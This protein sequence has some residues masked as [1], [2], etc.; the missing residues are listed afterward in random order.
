MINSTS[1]SRRIIVL[2]SLVA[3]TVTSVHASEPKYLEYFPEIEPYE[4]GYLR[5][6]DLHDIYYELCGNPDGKPVMVLHGG[7]GGGSYPT[8]R[9][10]H[11]PSKW[12]I[13][14]HDQ[15]GAGKS[16]PHCELKD[17]NTAALVEDVEALRKYLGL[18]KVHVFG[19]SWGS[20]LGVAY[21]EKYPQNVESLVLR[22]VFLGS[23]AEID[24]FYH[25]GVITHFP[26]QYE[27]LEAMIPEPR[28]KHFPKQLF[29]L[30]R[31]GDAETKR[32]IAVGWASYEIR[33]SSINGS[34]EKV[35]EY[36]KTW[37]PYDFS[38]IENYYMANGCF[39]KDEELLANAGK[40]A[41]I[42]TIIVQGRFDVVCPPITAWK[43]H[44]KLPKSRLVIVE[45]GAHSAGDPPMRSALIEAV[46]SVE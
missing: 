42:P 32:R 24:H 14:L 4:T 25:G 34:D 26:D 40:L 9:R 5:V 16:K 39:V 7:P 45:N 43:L 8:L 28:R 44:K 20:T 3:L 15:R 35:A 19:G 23:Q 11:D 10:F 12:K 6:S 41:D 2:G 46:R 37:D 38:L 27:K 18:G 31:D 21:A 1:R 30:L 17:N 33:I 22:G 13:I 36:F 29:V